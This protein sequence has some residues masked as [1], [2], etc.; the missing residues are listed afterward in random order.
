MS[1]ADQ[2]R[3]KNISNYLPENW[4][5]LDAIDR[6]VLLRNTTIEAG[7]VLS[8]NSIQATSGGEITF[9]NKL[10]IG[11]SPTVSDLYIGSYRSSNYDNSVAM[12]INNA[13]SINE[14]RII[15]SISTAFPVGIYQVSFTATMTATTAKPQLN[16]GL[17]TRTNT[18]WTNGDLRG[19][20]GTI[21]PNFLTNNHYFNNNNTQFFSQNTSSLL[22]VTVSSYVAFAVGNTDTTNLSIDDVDTYLR[23]VRLG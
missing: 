8:T 3:D 23:V 15:G 18:A 5:P 19:G 9:G 14:Q 11:Y 17:Y 12:T 21:E 4:L 10:R 22:V 13:L 7:Y 1:T 2:P 16:F 20:Q 6:P